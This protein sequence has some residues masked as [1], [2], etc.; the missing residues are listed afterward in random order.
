MKRSSVKDLT[1]G[2]PFKLIMGFMIPLLCGLL[3]QQIYNMVDTFIVGRV[4]GVEALAGVGSTGSINFLIIGACVGLCS[5]FAIP[6]ARKFGEGD[7]QGLKN[8]VGNIVWL[9]TLFSIL[10]P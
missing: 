7:Y 9:S 10:L 2:S 4:M 5:G 8:Y 3:F 6:V 1:V